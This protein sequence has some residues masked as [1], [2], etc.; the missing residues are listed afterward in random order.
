MTNTVN[1][2]RLLFFGAVALLVL[3]R[4]LLTGLA[5]ASI[6]KPHFNWTSVVL[7]ITHIAVV[8]FL[9]YTS[10]MLIYW[11]V[12]LWGVI[13]TGN[14]SYMLWNRWMTSTVAEK[15]EWFGSHLNRWWPFAALALFH[16][17][18]TLVFLLPSIRA[19]LAD[20]RSLLDFEEDLE[21]VTPGSGPAEPQN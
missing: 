10:D 13:T 5:L 8:L 11:L 20:R 3:E 15:A 1:R 16:L 14:F 12:I 2:G 6:G 7:P 9:V 21:P 19:Y 18:L 4:L 17:I